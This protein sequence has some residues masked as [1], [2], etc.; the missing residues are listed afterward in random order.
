MKV[1]RVLLTS[2]TTLFE[3]PGLE[4][5]DPRLSAL[6]KA[7]DPLVSRIESSHRE[8][9]HARQIVQEALLASGI[10]VSGVRRQ[11]HIQNGRYDLV[12][13]IGGDGTV[14]DIARF[15]DGTPVL[16]VNS[17]PSSSYG[18]FTCVTADALAGMLA[19]I[20]QDEVQPVELARIHLIIDGKRHIQ[21]VLND[22]LIGDT[23]PSTTS[24]YVIRIGDDEEDQK[25][26][27]VWV[28]TAAG[29]T[30]A[31]L[32]AGGRQMDI[33][34]RRLQYKVREPCLQGLPAQHWKLL[35]GVVDGPVTLV[36]RMIRGGAFLD[37]RRVAVPLRF[38]SRVDIDPGAP[39]L[40]I[41]LQNGRAR[42]GTA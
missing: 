26:S 22:V 39:P 24:R 36:S 13:S 12:I 37:G 25:S 14:L 3:M 30:G 20:Q 28:S 29:S 1:R 17:S 15:L 19:Q 21:P 11:G 42:M 18:H 32:S 4:R 41:Y 16:A 40:R 27:G 38:G 5:R 8:T 7:G 2:K 34:D 9:V 31:M 6:L 23:V 35:G 33:G 10:Q